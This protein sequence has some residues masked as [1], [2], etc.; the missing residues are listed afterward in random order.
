MPSGADFCIRGPCRAALDSAGP[1]R[2]SKVDWADRLHTY[3]IRKQD[4]WIWRVQHPTPPP[5]ERV[6]YPPPM[7]SALPTPLW[8]AL[9]TPLWSALHTPPPCGARSIP[10]MWSA[11]LK[12]GP[13]RPN[14][15]DKRVTWIF[16]FALHTPLWSALPTPLCSAL[17]T[18]PVEHAPYPPPP[19]SALHTPIPDWPEGYWTG[20]AS[21][22]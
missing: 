5:V 18:P 20:P 21:G 15:R 6:Q 10:P 17:H 3:A 12:K 19:W 14:T 13:I 2:R 7:W 16:E 1:S 8:S 9:H 11:N 4:R 22:W